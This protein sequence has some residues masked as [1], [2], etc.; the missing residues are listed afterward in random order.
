MILRLYAI[1]LTCITGYLLLSG[2]QADNSKETFQEITVQ[3]INIVE[4]DGSLKMV[5][6]NEKR[7]HP[8]MMD[9]K[10]IAERGRP[11]GIIFFNEEQDE[12][13]GLIYQGNKE[14]GAMFVLSVDQYK[15]DQVMQLRH[16]TNREG[17]NQYGLNIWQRDKNFTLPR[18]VSALDSLQ[19]A[20]V[21]GP[22][23][24][25]KLYEMNN[26]QNIMASRLFVGKK[27]NQ[28]AGMF[29]Q[30]QN[31]T[32]RLRIYV[33]ENNEPRMEVLDSNRTVIK[34]LLKE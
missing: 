34:D 12:V 27:Y 4:P 31:G 32:E 7:Q 16:V 20:G 22:E 9:G 11:P 8:G 28:A 21:S 2:F 3:R 26:G 13:G 5:L 24:N 19:K 25:Q 17:D 29:I 33:D 14:E 6:S 10:V 1:T 18:L 23:I 30:D 15:N